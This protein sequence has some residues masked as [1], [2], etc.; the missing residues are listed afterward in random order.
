MKHGIIRSALLAAMMGL[1]TVASAQATESQSANY[2]VYILLAI[3]VL[4][5]FALLVQ[6]SDNLM[7]IEAR[8]IVVAEPDQTFSVFPSWSEWFPGSF[9]QQ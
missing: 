7:A 6:V 8:E 9:S 4:V 1:A 2:L 3:A 5:F